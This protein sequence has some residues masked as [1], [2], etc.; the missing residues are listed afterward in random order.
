[1]GRANTGEG[2]GWIMLRDGLTAP[3]GGTAL[4]P[5]ASV[6]LL[7]CAGDRGVPLACWQA[8]RDPLRVMELRASA[9]EF[10]IVGHLF[11]FDPNKFLPQ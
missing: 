2:D 3:A 11:M 1:M 5:A 10:G 6:G 8:V 7:N 9:H 4:E